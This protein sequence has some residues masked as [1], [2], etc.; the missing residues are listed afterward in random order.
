MNT[1]IY[2]FGKFSS[3]K[4][5]SLTNRDYGRLQNRLT[6]DIGKAHV[7]PLGLHSLYLLAANSKKID[8]NRIPDDVVTMNSEFILS[9]DIFQKQLVRIVFPEDIKG[10]HD[11]SVY[12]AIGIACLGAKEKSYVVVK[13]N[14]S[15][16]KL[17]IEK[18]VF[19]PEREKL[20]YL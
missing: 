16:Q 1:K 17:L 9:N 10:K 12:S 13:Q 11:I 15:E 18:I 6:E 19:Q 20:F 2:D 4:E 5:K 3:W 8:S 14:T 7:S